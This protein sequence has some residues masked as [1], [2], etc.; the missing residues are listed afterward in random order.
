[1]QI[2]KKLLTVSELAEMMSISPQTIYNR[3]SK[4]NRGKSDKNFEVPYI[5]VGR[6]IRFPWKDADR[7]CEAKSQTKAA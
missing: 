5:K 3:I 4:F 1:M 6:S 7:F 2:E